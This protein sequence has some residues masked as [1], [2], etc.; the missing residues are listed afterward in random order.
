[1]V[2]SVLFDFFSYTK[3][4]PS[5]KRDYTVERESRREDT[6][7]K[8]QERVMC[9]YIKH[10]HPTAYEEAYKVYEKLNTMYPNKRDLRKTPYFINVMKGVEKKSF[11]MK[12]SRKNR[13]G[14][15]FALRIPLMRTETR[16]TTTSS[17]VVP[18]SVV[19]PSS[20]LP[21]VPLS[22]LVVPQPSPPLPELP[23]VPQPSPPLPELPP[24]YHNLRHLYLLM[25]I[26]LYLRNYN[27]ILSYTKFLTTS[28]FRNAMRK[29]TN[30][31]L[32]ISAI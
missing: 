11:G 9:E 5:D 17:I 32:R 22:P 20:P 19:A 7:R 16:A 24:L 26:K 31:W 6:R 3:N 27:K 15:E 4:M 2:F 8:R 23:S 25:R 21:V 1:M 14:Q 30:L 28:H 18:S 10:A 13:Q 29:W 12:P